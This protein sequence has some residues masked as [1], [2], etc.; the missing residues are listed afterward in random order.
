VVCA[1]CFGSTLRRLEE[2]RRLLF[3]MPPAL[4]A[5]SYLVR[6]AVCSSI[7]KVYD[8]ARISNELAT[9]FTLLVMTAV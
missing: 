9:P 2:F 6:L 5:Y 7:K 4:F 1:A 8:S 3:V